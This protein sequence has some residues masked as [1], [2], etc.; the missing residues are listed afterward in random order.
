M[1]KYDGK[2]F[3]GLLGK[4]IFRKQKVGQTVSTKPTSIKQ[5]A[6]TKAAAGTFRMASTLGSEI[7]LVLA[8]KLLLFNEGTIHCRLNGELNSILAACK[9]PATNTFSFESDS[10]HNLAGLEMNSMSRLT[11]QLPGKLAVDIQD[12]LL[13]I[14]LPGGETARKL[15]FV[16]GSTACKMMFTVAFFRLH[17]GLVCRRA[18]EQSLM[19]DKNKPNLNGLCFSFEVPNDCLCLVS[20]ALQYY[21]GKYPINT[22]DL[23]CS[24]FIEAVYIKGV[25]DE[26]RNFLW[27]QSDLVFK[28]A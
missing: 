9:D 18:A 8:D 23:N 17:E 21:A 26:S 10:F 6:A 4:L 22:I 24:A 2:F 15:R 1:A 12:G 20:T 11:K 7:R 3:R 27:S 14:T 13:T 19:I 5:T 25:Y 28:R 16:K